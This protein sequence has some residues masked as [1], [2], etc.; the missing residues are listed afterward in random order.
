MAVHAQRGL[1]ADVL[2]RWVDT[3]QVQARA[4]ALAQTRYVDCM[5]NLAGTPDALERWVDT[6]RQRAVTAG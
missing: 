5:R 4:S 6:C 2:V 1:V 3:C